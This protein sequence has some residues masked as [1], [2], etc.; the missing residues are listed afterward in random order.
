MRNQDC[1]HY[2]VCSYAGFAYEE[3]DNCPFG[4]KHDADGWVNISE[5]VPSFEDSEKGMVLAV[6]KDDSMVRT[7]DW[8]LVSEYSKCFVKWKR[9][10]DDAPRTWITHEIGMSNEAEYECPY[11][12]NRQKQQSYF[13]PVCGRKIR[14][15]NM[16]ES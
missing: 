14:A 16:L 5:R 13:C 3:C 6:M 1:V 9:I 7:V 8:R 4:D 10:T 2:K 11:C 15:L 12:S